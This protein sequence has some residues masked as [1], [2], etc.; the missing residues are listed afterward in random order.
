MSSLLGSTVV[1][2]R[3]MKLTL[4]KNSIPSNFQDIYFRA[5]SIVTSV[6]MAIWVTLQQAVTSLITVCLGLMTVAR[7]HLVCTLDQHSIGVR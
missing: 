6:V 5:V 4:D 2:I 1:N 3:E 7:C